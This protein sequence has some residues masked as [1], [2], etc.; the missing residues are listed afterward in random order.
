MTTTPKLSTKDKERLR[1]FILDNKTNNHTE[2][3]EY[4]CEECGY[5]NEVEISVAV[6]TPNSMLQEFISSL[7]YTDLHLFLNDALG[8]D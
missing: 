3:M 1:D 7:G 4:D 5:R 6:L 2:W 8:L